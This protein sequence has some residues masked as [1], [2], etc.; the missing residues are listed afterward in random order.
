MLFRL[1]EISEKILKAQSTILKCESDVE[2]Q[3]SKHYSK[4]GK[5][6]T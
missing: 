2:N 5:I 1:A 3:T 4:H 6:N